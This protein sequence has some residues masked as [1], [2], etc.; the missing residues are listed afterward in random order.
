MPN[1]KYC[2]SQADKESCAYKRQLEAVSKRN[3]KIHAEIRRQRKM[4]SEKE[5]KFDS[6]EADKNSFDYFQG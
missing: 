6:M 1:K 5:F 4:R 2:G 3:K